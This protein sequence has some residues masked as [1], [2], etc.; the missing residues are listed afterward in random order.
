M[1]LN[2]NVNTMNTWEEIFA[3]LGEHSLKQYI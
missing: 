3:P 2:S 1:K